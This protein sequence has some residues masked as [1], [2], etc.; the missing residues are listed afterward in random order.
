MKTA[1]TFGLAS[2][3][4]AT[5]LLF[6]AASRGEEVAGAPPVA[7]SAKAAVATA[8]KTG[9]AG[10]SLPAARLGRAFRAA[11]AAWDPTQR[12]EFAFRPR[13]DAEVTALLASLRVLEVEAEG[14]GVSATAIAAA[15]L[16]AH[17]LRIYEEPA[18]LPLLEAAIARG[19]K[20]GWRD[21]EMRT[22]LNDLAIALRPTDPARSEA[23]A[24][25]ASVCPRPC[26]KDRPT[27]LY[28]E[29]RA[30]F[31]ATSSASSE[32]PL[33]ERLTIWKVA[34]PWMHETLGG[35]SLWYTHFTDTNASG[36]EEVRPFT[37][38]E[39][40]RERLVGVS[41][42]KVRADR[43]YEL[44]RLLRK[45]GDYREA[46]ERARELA[47]VRA[48]LGQVIEALEARH[49][50]AMALDRIGDPEG[51]RRL[52]AL[53][54]ELLDHYREAGH[55]RELNDL[56]R[57]LV[58]SR[59]WREADAALA[60]LDPWADGL[61][62]SGQYLRAAVRAG[63]ARIAMREGR[64]AEAKAF[65]DGAV[66][67]APPFPPEE[68]GVMQ[69]GLTV[70]RAALAAAEGRAD[71]ARRLRAEAE[72]A[73]RRRSDQEPSS[74][75]FGAMQMLRDLGGVDGAGVIAEIAG[76]SIDAEASGHPDY[77]TAQTLWQVAYSLA[78]AGRQA[79]AFQRM[80]RAAAIAVGRSFESVDDTD[81]GSLQL[82]RRDRWRYL[83]FVD[84]A[85]SAA[86]GEPPTEMT[87]PSRY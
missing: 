42:P 18:A 80:S 27:R 65:L 78:L 30:A 26:A 63:R 24:K 86:R 34:R 70:E 84:I 12:D 17:I 28:A 52:A 79:A 77:E 8:P 6:P 4:A 36:F 14:A 25:R 33:D 49:D 73:V 40:V 87:V 43:L 74:F 31:A 41:D 83:L 85:W 55:V 19:A 13:P 47:E 56:A 32:M 1:K 46:A 81:G 51:R 44:H 29:G 15:M 53:A 58:A 76:A 48:R 3:L 75:V 50:E 71:D 21:A 20:A 37:A 59:L 22:A 39:I 64:F 62:G 69:I 60:V 67:A 35:G 61:W 68:P 11:S 9:K 16:Q 45:S 2:A 10:T 72:D 82:M 54:P 66:A 5:L 57:D 38:L 7:A 23:L